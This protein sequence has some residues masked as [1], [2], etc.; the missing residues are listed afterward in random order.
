MGQ[1]K[2]WMLK[3]KTRTGTVWECR[4]VPKYSA[5]QHKMIHVGYG[6]HLL[7]EPIQGLGET[8]WIARKIKEGKKELLVNANSRT[9]VENRCR[10]YMSEHPY[11]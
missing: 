3:Q 4:G 9:Y 1:I 6:T 2:G 5:D 10:K 7:V 8:L 11:G